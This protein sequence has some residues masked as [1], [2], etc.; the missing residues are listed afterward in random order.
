MNLQNRK[1]AVRLTAVLIALI[2]TVC[3]FP[4]TS[5]AESYKSAYSNVLGYFAGKTPSFGSPGGE[6]IVFTMARSGKKKAESK[7]FADYCQKIEDMLTEHGSAVLHARKSTE[8]SRL[9]IALSSIGRDARNI[10]GFDLTQ[11]LC[12]YDYAVKQGVNGAVFAILALN[13]NKA[14]G[15]NDVKSRMVD[16]L[17][18]REASGGGW[19]LMAGGAADPDVTSMVIYALAPY[20]KA[21]SAI[22]RAVKALSS[23]QKEDGGFENMG[24]PNAESNA[25]VIT[26]LSTIGIDAGNDERFVK[27]GKSVVDALLTFVTGNGF[28]H[29]HGGKLNGTATEQA[30]YSLCAYDR[31]LKGKKDIFDL[32]DVKPYAEPT[33]EP[34]MQPTQTPQPA[35]TPQPQPTKT[36]SAETTDNADRTQEPSETPEISSQPQSSGNENALLPDSGTENTDENG[37]N[38]DEI[39]PTA[40]VP[41]E[42]PDNGPENGETEQSDGENKGG[43]TTVQKILLIVL[44]IAFIAIAITVIS[45][46]KN[47]SHR[48]K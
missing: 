20:S 27:N 7:Y 22:N 5:S 37:G 43:F 24:N 21:K 8:N 32:S 38:D 12:D 26:A 25:Q 11:P 28:S 46:I 19:S 3:A 14:Y 34:T 47:R 13:C 30:A 29:L 42:N 15:G 45:L 39:Q 40:D 2:L 44:P 16:M 35:D 41:S 17:L 10:A 48:K 31:F 1:F 33:E 6:W 23:M 4:F 36:P 9:V 18:S